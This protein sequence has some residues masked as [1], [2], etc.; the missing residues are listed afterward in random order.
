MIQ[1]KGRHYYIKEE[2][3]MNPYK[4]NNRYFAKDKYGN[5]YELEEQ[6]YL[7]LGGKL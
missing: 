5:K 4:W 7:N 1:V 2:E 6:D 3:L